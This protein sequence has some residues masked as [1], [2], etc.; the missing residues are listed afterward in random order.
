MLLNGG[1]PVEIGTF[2]YLCLIPW[3]IGLLNKFMKRNGF[4]FFFQFLGRRQD[5]L[6]IFFPCFLLGIKAAAVFLDLL[7]CYGMVT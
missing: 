1:I 7:S 2:L 4:L 5:Q 6:G 3:E